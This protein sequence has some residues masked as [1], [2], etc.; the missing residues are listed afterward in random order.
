MRA[1]EFWDKN[2]AAAVT[3]APLGWIYGALGRLR[4][5][6]ATPYRAGVPVI[7]I[8]N[9][10]AGGAGKTPVALAVAKYL[11]AKGRIV[12]F[13]SY[14]YGGLE[15]GP[16][17]VDPLRHS[18]VDVGDEALL[19]ARQAPA[20]IGH[21]RKA[22]ARL[23]VEDGAEILIMDDGFQYPFLYKDISIL[24]V[25]GQYGLGNGY[26]IPA[27][28]LRER[29]K[30]ALLRAAAVIRM[31]EDSSGIDAKLGGAKKIWEA[32]LM[33]PEIER[34]RWQGKKVVAFA[35]IG[36]PAKFFATLKN[37]GAE[38]I[39]THAFPDHHLFATWE[40]P[41]ILDQARKN[42]AV[43]VTTQKDA[44]RIDPLLRQQIEILPVDAV[45]T[46]D[47]ALDQILGAI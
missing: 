10:V 7:C 45:F 34:K 44:V 4:R 23:A 32:K 37:L 18:A 1:P 33:A 16:L 30:D 38:I 11:Q 40:L 5:A 42:G 26:L 12:H 13:L 3:F 20:W 2:C 27:G 22:A 28:P 14:G 35:A 15:E 9:V 17:L 25:D 24:V 47:K 29:L 41:L 6:L 43:A 46:D 36:R 19:L 21:D 39:A 8:G 31:G